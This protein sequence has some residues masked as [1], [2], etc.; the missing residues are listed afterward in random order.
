MYRILFI[1]FFLTCF[2]F[3]S[4]TKE[5]Q[6][7]DYMT[8]PSR[9]EVLDT[10]NTLDNQIYAVKNANGTLREITPIRV[11]DVADSNKTIVFLEIILI[12][13]LLVFFITGIIVIIYYLRAKTNFE[14]I[15]IDKSL[16]NKLDYY[17]ENADN[18]Q[19]KID[20]LESNF[21]Q[22]INEILI[23]KAFQ[24]QYLNQLSCYLFQAT[25][26]LTGQMNNEV[27]AKDILYNLFHGYNIAKLYRTSLNSDGTSRIDKDKFAA[28]AYLMEN[29]TLE[30]IPH[31]EYIAKNDPYE[32]NRDQAKEII[33]R[34]K[35]RCRERE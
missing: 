3:T 17:I 31:L 11:Y 9:I 4:N 25:Y 7:Q 28:F 12:I 34:I 21:Q 15:G 35:E 14:R 24:D 32:S 27:V 16:I 26:S 2:V 8:L 33:G 13:T 30:D 5:L 20:R 19:R 23:N 18:L 10:N 1:S 29:G 6:K 22:Q